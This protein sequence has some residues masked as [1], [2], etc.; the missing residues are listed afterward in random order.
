M[1][2]EAW[3]DEMLRPCPIRP[4]Y[5]VMWWL[6]TDRA[7]HAPAPES[8]VFAMGAGKNVIWVDS[9]LDLVAVSRWID[10]EKVDGWIERIMAS[11]TS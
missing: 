4:I 9:S 11:I 6:N 2:S 10:A 3:I 1:L 8:S 5:G 7:Y